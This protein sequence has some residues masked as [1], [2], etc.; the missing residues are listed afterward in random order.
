MPGMLSQSSGERRALVV[1]LFALVVS[2]A[3]WIGL[4]AWVARGTALPAG[5]R[6]PTRVHPVEVHPAQVCPAQV[7]RAQGKPADAIEQGKFLVA[8]RGL[9]DPNFVETVVLLIEFN[10]DGALGVIINRPTGVRLSRLLPQVEGLGEHEEVVYF[11]GPVSRR[12]ILMLFRAERGPKGTR[13]V[14]PNVHFGASLEIFE[15][16]FGKPGVEAEFRGYSGYAGWAPGQLEAEI[17]RG[18]WNLAAGDSRMIFAPE[19]LK[20]W[21]K[22]IDQTT[23]RFARRQGVPDGGRVSRDRARLVV[24]QRKEG[25]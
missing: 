10:D 3:A 1:L 24:F 11:G 21:P 19:P 8:R 17:D 2:A 22:L 20:V 7:Y 9:R 5:V 23:I 4:G 6:C 15:Q 25:S 13:L 14:L 12:R 16:V 18:D